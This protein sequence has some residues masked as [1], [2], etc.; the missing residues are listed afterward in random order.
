MRTPMP[1]HDPGFTVCAELGRLAMH[2]LEFLEATEDPEFVSIV[3]DWIEQ[4]PA[5]QPGYW[6]DNWNSYGLSIR[7]VVL[8]QQATARRATLDAAFC[9]RLDQSLFAQLSF[10]ASNL[11]VD[12]GGN[13]LIKNIKALLWGARYFTG[14][15]ADQWR[16]LALGL[17]EQQLQT[18]VLPDGGHDER[19]ASYHIQVFVDLCECY[20]L[21][22]NHQPGLFSQLRDRLGQMAQVIVDT[23]HPDDAPSLFNDAGLH[24]TWSP[25]QALDLFEQLTGGRPSPRPGFCYPDAGYFGLRSGQDLLIA[26]C[27]A[28]AP[29]HLPAHGHGDI[30]AFEWSIGSRRVFVDHGVHEYGAGAWRQRSRSTASHN[31]VTVGDQDQCEFYASFRVGRRARIL[32]A[33]YQ[34]ESAGFT[35][36][37]SHDG[38]AH[39]PGRPVHRRTIQATAD[40]LQ[41]QDVVEGGQGQPVRSRLLCHPGCEVQ[42]HSSGGATISNQEVVVELR[43]R[44]LV[45]VQPHSWC[46]DFGVQTPTQQLVMEYGPAP[47]AGGF[48]LAVT[49]RG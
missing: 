8:M 37:G 1:W 44:H 22:E 45:R 18:Q 15:A 36:T 5:Y 17:L 42:V 33:D 19:S 23:T 35:L 34:A 26:D 49:A 25:R 38:Y 46:P 7:T 4:N 32:R 30:L 9:A 31:T 11:E 28:I 48:T 21:E 6:T 2:Y 47:C 29:D 16:T 12:L 20:Q 3:T 14:A 24:T 13:H 27:G 41:V 39:L 40:L 10:L 43:T